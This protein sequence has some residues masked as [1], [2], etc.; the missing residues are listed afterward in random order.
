MADIAFGIHGHFYQPSREDPISGQIPTER[1]SEPYKNWNELIYHHCYK[2]NTDLRNFERISF[3]IGPTLM[4]WMEKNY[5]GTV[6]EIIRQENGNYE[7]FG[8]SNAL[9]QS[10]HHT[11]LPLSTREDK[12]TQ[13]QWGI[14]DFQRRFGHSPSGMWLP[15]AAV[16]LESLEIMADSGIE[17]TILAP[18]QADSTDLDVSQPYWI[19]LPNQK[20][21]G[22]FFYNRE[23]ST[24]IS[25]DPLS[26]VNADRFAEEKILPL[27][28][29]DSP[30]DQPKYFLVA[31]DGE[32][33]GHHQP[34]RDQFLDHLMNGALSQYTIQHTYPALWFRQ[35]PPVQT[36]RIHENTSWSCH[37]GV[38]RWSTGCGCTSLSDWKRHLRIAIDQV[39]A[40]VDREFENYLQNFTSDIWRFRNEYWEVLSGETTD[41]QFI[42]LF[43]GLSLT[44]T[45]KYKIKNLLLAQVDRQKMYTSCGWFFDDFDR[46]EPQ[47]VV[48]YAAQSIYWTE[49]ATQKALIDAVI[50]YFEKIRSQM[51]LVSGD[52]ILIQQYRRA[53]QH[54]SI[55]ERIKQ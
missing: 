16:D 51:N 10:Y 46:I 45:E 34:F 50:P 32:L 17:F 44:E 8:V 30:N 48:S 49:I 4:D 43:P 37:H 52:I 28:K 15:E 42:D 22:V 35:H 29:K 47:N 2:P 23:L 24:Q 11:I 9:A 27:F 33:Y 38:S 13:I 25:F 12:I 1:G 40:I 53:R 18:W 14:K 26:T 6:L 41:E 31:S 3:N 39:A 36:I 21:I 7:K 5:P 55:T 20:R 54:Y 19:E